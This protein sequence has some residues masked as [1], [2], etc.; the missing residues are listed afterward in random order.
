VEELKLEHRME[1]GTLLS[2]K[3]TSEVTELNSKQQEMTTYPSQV[4]K[5]LVA[6]MKEM[7]MKK[8]HQESHPKL[9]FKM[10]P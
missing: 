5:S 2:V 6:K 8:K 10:H 1:N 9:L 7:M 3:L 4:L